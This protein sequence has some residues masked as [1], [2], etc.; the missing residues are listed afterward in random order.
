MTGFKAGMDNLVKTHLNIKINEARRCGSLVVYLGL[1]F[2]T[3]NKKEKHLTCAHT[4]VPGFLECYSS[5]ELVI[6]ISE[7]HLKTKMQAEKK[8]M[9]H[10]VPAPKRL[11]QEGHKFKTSLNYIVRLCL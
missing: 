11:R 6:F 8:F 7:K 5:L 4:I 2:R 3:E 10:I 9:P 1:I